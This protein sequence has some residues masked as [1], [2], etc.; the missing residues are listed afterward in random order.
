MSR[1]WWTLAGAFALVA[2]SLVPV[3]AASG[4]GRAA[5][6]AAQAA[7]A[8]K[9]QRYVVMMAADPLARSVGRKNLRTATARA[10]AVTL[11]NGQD[12]A[13]R[14]VG[15]KSSDK[16]Y[17]YTRALNGFAVDLTKTQ[18][19]KLAKRSDVARVMPDVLRKK[20]T[21]ASPQFLGL[22]GKNGVWAKGY[23]GEGVVIGV[24]DTGIWPEHPSFADDGSYP[25]PKVVLEN[26]AANPSCN[27]GNTAANPL[28]KPF[29]CNNKLIGAR[30]FLAGY[31]SQVPLDPD[32]YDS[33]RD[34]DG[35]GTHTAST[36]GGN[37]GVQAQIFGVP[38]GKVSGIAPRAQII[39]Y[40]ALGNLGGFTSDLA[41]AID[42]AVTDGV[43][44]INYS[45][46]GG[47]SLIGADDVSFL[48][49]ADAGVSV[50]ASAGNSGPGAGT[51]GG[52]ATVPWLTSVGASTQPR[53][54][55]ATVVLGNG[56][57]LKGASVTR[58]TRTLGLVDAAS[59]GDP[60]CQLGKLDPATVKGKIV[61]CLRG[62]NGRAAKGFAVAQAGGAGMVLYNTNDV[63][64]LFTDNFQVPT[65]ML[66]NTPGLAVKS[67]IAGSR[68][69]TARIVADQRSTWPSAPSMA[70]FSS[71]G[72]DASAQD[73]IKPDVTAPGVQ[74]LA[75][76]SPTPDPGG[77]APG[78]LFMSIAGTSMSSPHV[79]GL[80]ALIEQAHP[81]WS[82]A[83]VKSALMTTAYQSVVDNDRKT[84]AN[85]FAMG[86]GHVDPAGQQGKGTPFDPG[87]VYDA[88]F[89]EYLG[90]LCDAGPGIF[91][92]PARTCARL[93]A[94]GVPTTAPNLNYPSIGIQSVTGT[95]TVTRTVTRVAR[96]GSTSTRPL[97]FTARVKAPAG[98][99]VTV[100]PSRL[101]LAPGESASYTVTV[102]NRTAALNTWTFGSLT[103]RNESYDVY[104]PIAVK[105]QAF[106]APGAVSGTGAAGTVDIPVKFGYTG[107]YTAAAHGLVPAT[108]TADTV[109][110]DPDQT[111]ST[112]DGFSDAHPITVS[113]AALL[114][115]SLPPDSVVDPN[116]DLD[117]Y[118]TGPDGTVV[119]QSTAGG[120]DEQVDIPNPVDGTYTAW[121]HGWGVGP[122]PVAYTMYDWAIPA[123]PGGGNLA[124]TAAPASA[125][126]GGTGTVTAAWSAAP[127]E[128]N[129]GA[130]SHSD[131]NGVLALTLV[132]VDNR[133]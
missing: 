132:E 67:Y 76:A 90:F 64:N 43:D 127:A 25:P 72:P 125:T 112:T 33:A 3:T 5:A 46:G 82:S 2:A 94:A 28:D 96:P 100:T 133:P 99:S 108:V 122:T 31:K 45:I 83:M 65:V 53:V 49:A 8:A 51:I 85:P 80:F 101:T 66:D 129:L 37:A 109:A 110:Q 118:V 92:N 97:T 89:N 88:G 107:A 126:L 128:W 81:D 57:E 119:A 41:G 22:A 106:A 6:P 70:I 114:R 1:R 75:G 29:T 39:A 44:V 86:A 50:A 36:S 117:L 116:T 32:E 13:L 17:S 59:A 98:F 73:I 7:Q 113:G 30:E 77:E 78:Q 123:T 79:A 14:A 20:T 102:T 84:P 58:G 48:F 38:K 121:V 56:K 61:L 55:A 42:Q 54:F 62:G 11:V 87:L 27:F 63:D 120:T 10:R 26:T 19:E 4:A 105:A 130:V 12:A 103:W 34:D 21:D 74:I 124:V 115:I 71:R 47:P 95:E 69:P 68:R 40:K 16:I 9:T 18:A 60:L 91:A 23:T 93:A 24:I 104:S 111:F 35:H 131:A 52:P 15:K